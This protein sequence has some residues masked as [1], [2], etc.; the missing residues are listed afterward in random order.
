M[1]PHGTAPQK[2]REPARFEQ[3]A[4]EVYCWWTLPPEVSGKDIKVRCTQ[5]GRWLEIKVRGETLFDHELFDAVRQADVIW[6]VEKGDFH[7]TLTKA[8]KSKLWEQL[9]AVQ[10]IRRDA[11]GKAIPETIPEP[12]SAGDRVGLFQNMLEGDDGERSNYD[13]LDPK[14][15]ELVDAIRK[16]RSARARGD[17]RALYEAEEDLESF[18]RLVI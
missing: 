10:E 4:T 3:A 7:L 17:D 18:G 13:D 2:R 9:G 16:Y 5:A 11:E 1:E 8:N 15:R 14:S 12:M 6:T